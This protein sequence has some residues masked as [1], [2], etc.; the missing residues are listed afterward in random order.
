[1]VMKDFT[2]KCF[3]KLYKIFIY[4]NKL[5]KNKLKVFLIGTPEHGN[6]GDQMIIEAQ[7][8]FLKQMGITP[9]EVPDSMYP[10]FKQ[11]VQDDKDNLFILHGGGNFGN[12]YMRA[13]SMRYD[14]ISN[15]PKSKIV[16]MPQ[17]IYFT[18]DALGDE[19]LKESIEIFSKHK[20]LTLCAREQVSY[21]QMKENFKDN[22]VILVPD[23]VLSSDIA[24]N[25]NIKRK[26]QILFLIR[27]DREKIDNSA[28]LQQIEHWA[29]KNG[30][31]IKYSDT[32]KS[33]RISVINRRRELRKIFKTISQSQFVVTDR[34]HGMIFSYIN[35]T[36][37]LV[38]SN[39]NHKV[40]S[41]YDWIKDGKVE[42]YQNTDIDKF[43]K[44]VEKKQNTDLKYKFEIL[45]NYI[46]NRD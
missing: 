8:K 11:Q 44:N 46:K 24:N 25:K 31:K 14:I 38:F 10:Q 22:N 7:I 39:Y 33:Y 20:N 16:M 1:V 37:A 41:S 40:I 9:F 36:P 45:E 5:K 19:K 28:Q 34:L 42:L 29:S 27:N 4:P 17:T 13:Q 30:Y 6:L 12:E 21:D 32:L 2:N 35:N 3:Y 26:K 43:V 18:K 23:I 15:Y